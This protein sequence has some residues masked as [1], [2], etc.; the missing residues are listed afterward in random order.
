MHASKSSINDCGSSK[1]VP[2]AAPQPAVNASCLAMIGSSAESVS[3]V[4]YLTVSGRSS[5]KRHFAD[6]GRVG[7]VRTSRSSQKIS[8][9]S[10][11]ACAGAQT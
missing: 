9:G 4:K 10:L 7:S 3:N 5:I 11:G 1:P 2:A 6:R 8:L